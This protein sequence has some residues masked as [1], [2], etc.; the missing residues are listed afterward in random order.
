MILDLKTL[1]TVIAT[2]ELALNGEYT[3]EVKIGKPERYPDGNEDYYCP[4]QITGIGKENIRYSSGV[5]KIQALFLTL[6]SIGSDLYTSKEYETGALRWFPG[7][8]SHDLGFPVLDT[9]K[10]LYPYPEEK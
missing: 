10:D 5:D 6:M 1:G 9:M 8:R 2:R 7:D 3:V 4:Y